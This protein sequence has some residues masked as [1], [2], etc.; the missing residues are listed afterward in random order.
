MLKTDNIQ[1]WGD[2]HSL[3]PYSRFP[4]LTL[5]LKEGV[6]YKTV[7]EQSMLQVISLPFTI[8]M[9]SDSIAAW[10]NLCL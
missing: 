1:Q 2:C 8:A 5:L 3:Q 7:C 6:S 10:R 9:M 4:F